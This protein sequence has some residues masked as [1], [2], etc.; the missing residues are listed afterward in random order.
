MPQDTTSS[1]NQLETLFFSALDTLGSTWE[2]RDANSLLLT[3]LFHKCILRSDRYTITPADKNW[4]ERFK[5]ATLEH[6]DVA[7]DQLIY[8]FESFGSLHEDFETIYTPAIDTLNRHME[9]AEHLLAS[10]LI[11]E[12]ANTELQALNEKDCGTFFNGCLHKIARYAER[13]ARKNAIPLQLN[14][15]LA[16][17]AA[18]Q[19]KAQIFMPDAGYGDGLI[20]LG[21]YAKNL[22]PY[23]IEHKPYSLAICRMNLILNNLSPQNTFQGE[24]LQDHNLVPNIDLVVFNRPFGFHADSKISLT[25]NYLSLPY[26]VNA[27]S[28][29]SHQLHIQLIINKLK[30]NGRAICLLPIQLLREEKEHYKLRQWLV[31]RDYIEAI[32]S[33]PYNLLYASGMPLCILILR[34]EKPTKSSRKILFI[35]STQ[36]PTVKQSRLYRELTDD[37][38]D[39]LSA[40]VNN[41]V[42]QAQKEVHTTI[43]TL[44]EIITNNYQLEPR[45]YTSSFTNERKTLQEQGLLATL[46]EVFSRSGPALWFDENNQQEQP[47]VHVKVLNSSLSNYQLKLENLPI[48]SSLPNFNARFVNESSLILHKKGQ[49]ITWTYFEYKNMPILVDEELM[50]FQIDQS[51]LDVEYLLIQLQSSF[52]QQQ[53]YSIQYDN[54]HFQELDYEFKQLQISLP[55]LEEQRSQV[56]EHKIRLLKK[57]EAKVEELR[58]NLNLDR[59]RAQSVQNRILSSL[60]HELG[61]RLPAVLTEFKNLKDYLYDKETE[62]TPVDFSDPIFPIYEGEALEDVDRL[63]LILQRIEST[64]RLAITS[65]DATSNIIE[66]GRSSLNL[67]PIVIRDLLEEVKIIYAGHKNLE[68]QIEVEEDSFGQE[69]YIEAQIDRG[70]MITAFTNLID[71]AIRH[72]FSSNRKNI[73]RFQ[74]GLSR[75]HQEVIILYKNNGKPF[76]KNFTFEDFISY[77]NYA[78]KSGHSGIGGFLIA[79]IIENHNGTLSFRKDISPRDYFKVQFE[80]SI[81]VEH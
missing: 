57:E 51:K 30:S 25:Q 34:K 60:Q 58:K 44:Q 27:L 12:Q 40:L 3:I 71:N 10:L 77:G 42:A 35:D 78:G 65:I 2:N 36:L 56:K 63:G 48:T 6:Q 55:P 28:I 67:R 1:F 54:K 18:P 14:K 69:L 41:P 79:Q 74:A 49:L 32:I 53:L 73:V 47:Y 66:A 13:K 61:N 24:A 72:G 76:P 37:Q 15:L 39:S 16:A 50:V 5:I 68:I 4:F 26:A 38:I 43:A 20:A 52:V 62:A 70:Q 33:L 8:T 9:E 64:L 81:P 21:K 19:D 22:Q 29:N 59:Q 7:V 80:L 45:W 46:Q 23:V 75:L 11:F 17:L 31:N